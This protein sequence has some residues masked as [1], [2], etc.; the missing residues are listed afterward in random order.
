[1]HPPSRCAHHG[2]DSCCTACTEETD[3][4]GFPT[5]GDAN[6]RRALRQCPSCKAWVPAKLWMHDVQNAVFCCVE[7]MP[8]AY[9][10]IAKHLEGLVAGAVGARRT[11]L[12]A[13]VEKVRNRARMLRRNE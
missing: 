3:G 7:C 4:F 5:V 13:A 11:K 10:R 12:I 8:D 1:V 9:A 6:G 2:A